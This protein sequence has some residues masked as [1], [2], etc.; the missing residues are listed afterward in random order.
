M[1]EA[2]E[3]AAGLLGSLAQ[4]DVSLAEASTYRVGGPAALAVTVE[5]DAALATVAG[6]VMAT[7]VEVFVVGKGSNLLV[8]DA[9]FDGLAVRLGDH[10][11][12]VDIDGTRVVAG[13]SASLPVVARRSGG[14]RADRLRMGRR[15]ARIDGRGG[16]H[17]RRRAR[18]GHGRERGEGPRARP[19]HRGGCMGVCRP[20]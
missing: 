8:A 20:I 16:A 14:G 11:A 10:F 6:V 3:R 7:G 5:D 19:G 12:L 4:R 13:G 1:T 18:L 17:E 9:G 15:G 2:V